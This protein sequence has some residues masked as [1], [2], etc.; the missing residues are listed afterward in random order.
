MK[1]IA[2]LTAQFFDSNGDRIIFGGAERYLVDLVQLIKEM[3]YYPRVYQAGNHKWTRMYDQIEFRSLPS[4]RSEYDTF[5]E[6]NTNFHN[7]TKDSHYRLYFSLNMCYP[8]ADPQSIAISHGVWWDSESKAYYRSPE[9][10]RR[11]EASLNAPK[12]IVSVDTNTINWVR[13]VF[14][15][16]VQKMQYIPNYVDTQLFKP[17]PKE[18]HMFTVLYPRSLVG[19]RGLKETQYAAG[20]L[21]PRYHD[22]E[23]YFVGRGAPGDEEIMEQWANG[24]TRVRYEWFDMKDMPRA[25]R[26]SDVVLIPSK[27]SEGTSLSALE[28]LACGKLVIAGCTGGLTDLILDEYNGFLISVSTEAIVE[29]VEEIYRHKE[30][31][32]GIMK[33]ARETALSFSKERWRAQW[34]KLIEEV[35]PI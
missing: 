2:I 25:Y 13:A 32:R 19:A 29:K 12:W 23:F 30:Y 33:N 20:V 18:G 34:Q 35:Y 21:L 4:F 7:V 22:M 5:P 3:G 9:W 26:Q 14:P 10:M 16:M 15:W 8:Q 17:E 28:A 11:L 24:S 31:M 27:Y 6:L 1:S